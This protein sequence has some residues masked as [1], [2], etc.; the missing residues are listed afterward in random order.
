MALNTSPAFGKE[1]DIQWSNKDGDGGATGGLLTANTSK[2]ATSGVVLTVYTAPTNGGFVNF[3]R[4][5]PAGTNVATVIRFFINNGSSAGTAA[6]NV[7]FDE[8]GICVQNTSATLRSFF[9]ITV[10]MN[11]GLPGGYKILATTG[12]TT[13]S[14]VFIGVVARKL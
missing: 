1:P 7:L 8:V 5:K 11:I 3:I 9:D 13:A 14:G 6:N 2:D 4:L 10:P 12:T